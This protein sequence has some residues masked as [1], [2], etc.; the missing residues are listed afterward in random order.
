MTML[1]ITMRITNVDGAPEEAVKLWESDFKL[2]GSRKIVYEPFEVSCGVVPDEI[3]AVVAPG[4]SLDANICFQ[5]SEAESDF[6]LI[7]EPSGSPAVYLELPQ[8][9]PG[10]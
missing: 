4:D 2:I 7:Y 6:Q 1:L 8:P 5:I 9:N 10:K 3:N